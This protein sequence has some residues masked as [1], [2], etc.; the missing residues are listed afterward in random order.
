MRQLTVQAVV[1]NVSGRLFALGLQFL[2]AM[3]LARL[4]PP[5]AF[6]TVAMI[7]V[8]TGFA[9]AFSDLGLGAALIQRPTIL[10][11]HTSSVFWLSVAVGL[12]MMLFFLLAAPLVAGFYGEAVL[13]P[14]TMLVSTT[15]LIGSLQVVPA[16]L[17]QRDLAFRRLAVGE[18][19]AIAVSGTGGVVLAL[20]GYGVWSLAWQSVIYAGVKSALL[21]LVLTDWRPTALPRVDG[22]HDL[23]GFSK[24]LVGFSVINYW[25]RNADN[26]LV[27]RFLG[28]ADLGIYNRAYSL[29]LLPLT[30][31]SQTVG[32]V[33]FPAFSA[34]QADRVRVSRIYLRAVRMVGLIVFPLM[35][36]LLVV[37][38][39]FVLAA[40]GEQW[41]GL[42]APLRWFCIVAIAQSIGSMNGNLY[43]SQGRTK[44]QFVVGSVVGSAGIAAIVVGMLWGLM[45]VVIAYSVFAVVV[46]Y[47]TIRIAV[48]L[49]GLTFGD[50]VMALR[51]VLGCTVVS[52][53]GML[54]LTA[55]LPATLPRAVHVV[56]VSCFGL[57]IFAGLLVGLRSEAYQ[58]AREVVQD[59]LAGAGHGG[60]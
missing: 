35:T 26:L 24:H 46:T 2:L 60:R 10:S 56:V 43:L 9:A 44:L 5:R 21:L 15:F 31:I 25:F 28:A 47:P 49:V 13:T 40:F 29:M 30:L 32:Q 3:V 42:V 57:S 38:E 54:A 59:L 19:L 34:I 39:P 53:A 36:A 22:V 16:A 58:D 17:L 8:F 1:W 23:L 55:L 45:G 27:G 41:A 12:M 52:G 33:M 37:C 11:R 48:S 50:V 20:H 4:L 6:G 14:L 18:F 7:T 51:G